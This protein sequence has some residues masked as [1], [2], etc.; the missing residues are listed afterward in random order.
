MRDRQPEVYLR[1]S[2]DQRLQ[3]RHIVALLAFLAVLYVA[4]SAFFSILR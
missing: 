3:P 2:D 1:T 4:G